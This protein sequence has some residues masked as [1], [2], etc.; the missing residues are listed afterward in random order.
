MVDELDLTGRVRVLEH[1]IHKLETSFEAK[2]N[3]LE[4]SIGRLFDNLQGRP[5]TPPFKEIII[6]IGATLAV[7]MTVAGIIGSY[8]ERSIELSAAKSAGARQ[9]LEYRLDKLEQHAA[10][11]TGL[12]MV[13]SFPRQ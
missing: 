3:S 10:K 8:V 7:V 2:F 12:V 11:P 5:V 9:V 4:K 1:G 13:P 6:S